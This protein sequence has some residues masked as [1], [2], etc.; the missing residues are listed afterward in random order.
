MLLHLE[1]K[2]DICPSRAVPEV[3]LRVTARR[4]EGCPLAR[5]GPTTSLSEC[6][7]QRMT[8]VRLST[9]RHRQLPTNPRTMDTR[10][11]VGMDRSAEEKLR[12][13]MAKGY[14]L[15]IRIL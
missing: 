10:L 8:T 4:V 12:T 3:V 13:R 11:V 2:S 7:R 1:V 6:D 5:V 9:R 14:A 15:N